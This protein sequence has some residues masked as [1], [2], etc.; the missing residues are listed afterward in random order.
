MKVLPLLFF[1][2]K[3]NVKHEKNRN[4]DLIKDIQYIL[5]FVFRKK[6]QIQNQITNDANNQITAHNYVITPERKTDS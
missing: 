6:I 5:I 3:C 4:Y 1:I 2:N